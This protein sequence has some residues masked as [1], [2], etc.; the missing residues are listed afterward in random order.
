MEQD[1]EYSDNDDETEYTF[2]SH[3]TQSNVNFKSSII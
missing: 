1:R 2:K 3:I